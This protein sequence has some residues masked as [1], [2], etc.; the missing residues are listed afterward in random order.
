LL[1]GLHW[2]GRKRIEWLGGQGR[3][4]G[5]GGGP[6][7]GLAGRVS[8]LRGPRSE[9]NWDR[10]RGGAGRS[11]GGGGRGGGGRRVRVRARG[12]DFLAAEG[13]WRCGPAWRSRQHGRREDR[14]G[15]ARSA[16]GGGHCHV[17]PAVAAAARQENWLLP[18]RERWELYGSREAESPLLQAYP[19]NQACLP[20]PSHAPSTSFDENRTRY[21]KKLKSPLLEIRL[22]ETIETA[23]PEVEE[24][25]VLHPIRWS[26]TLPPEPP[27]D[28]PSQS[29]RGKMRQL[30][31]KPK[32]ETSRDKKERKQAMQEARQ[33]ITT[34]VL[35]TLAVVVLLIVVFVYVATRP[36]VTE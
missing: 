23:V 6:G 30:K 16:S 18:T 1:P 22:L 2:S 31:G 7:A 4:P 3:L 8:W 26:V 34:V 9:A 10:A 21:Q 29:P 14:Q 25:E 35:P 5:G 11:R 24:K 32:K 19:T 17:F 12:F 28:T 15:E 33:Q 20:Y 13:A 27:L 36:T